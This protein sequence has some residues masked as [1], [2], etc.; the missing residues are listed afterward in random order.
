M[1]S[2]LPFGKADLQFCLP[3]V[4]PSLHFS[5]L[6]DMLGPLPIWQEKM[7]H[8][9]QENLFVLDNRTI[10]FSSLEKQHTLPGLAFTNPTHRIVS[11]KPSK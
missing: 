2:S 6:H 1:N 9:K 4:S 10:L 5:H 7:K 3:Q 8:A 11:S